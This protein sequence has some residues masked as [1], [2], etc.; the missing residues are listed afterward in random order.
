MKICPSCRRTYPDDSL[1]FCLD[2]GSVLTAAGEAREA[3][4]ILLNQPAPTQAGQPFTRVSPN[5]AATTPFS[6]QPPKKKSRMWLWAL[7][8][9]GSLALLCGGGA[10]GLA[11]RAYVQKKQA[12]DVKIQDPAEKAAEKKDAEADSWTN[13]D[14]GSSE[15]GSKLTMEKYRQ[16]K[17]GM[18]YEEVVAILGSEGK[19][20]HDSSGAGVKT[21]TYQWSG[22]NFE[23]VILTFQNGKLNSRTQVGL[24]SASESA[25]S[26]SVSREQYDRLKDGMSY[27]EV[28][29]I[30]GS[31]G[32]EQFKSSIAGFNIATYQWKGSGFSS[33]IVTFQN[34]RLQSKTQVG[35]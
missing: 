16:I 2:D 28:V 6:M 29:S 4:T 9:L 35:L 1:N 13:V 7:L 30:L 18:T 23:V 5:A 22:D 15:S 32:N 25:K 11:W 19:V 33:I 21:A 8:V 24:E 34:D 12:A 17:D 10:A 20:L 27:K 3:E 14:T 31:E 26:P